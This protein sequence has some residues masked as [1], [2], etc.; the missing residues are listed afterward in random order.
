MLRQ[1]LGY[2]GVVITDSLE[3]VAVRQRF[4]DEQV[5]VEAILAGAVMLL[6]PPRGEFVRWSLWPC[7]TPTTP[8]TWAPRQPA[9]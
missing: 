2:D 7:A 1:R 6:M 5:P 4:G 8:P 9:W 3:M